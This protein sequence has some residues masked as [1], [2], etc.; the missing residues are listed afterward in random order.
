MFVYQNGKLYV[1]DGNE[2][3]GVEIYPDSIIKIESTRTEL[4]PSARFLTP[5]ECMSKFNIL[6][7]GSYKFPR[8]KEEIV[9]EKLEP[10]V[11]EEV[12]EDEST[13]NVKVTTRASKRK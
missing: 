1:Q 5:F 4:S 9:E 6:T 7:E 13:N 11:I 10:Q 3:I 12:I 8:E 2:I